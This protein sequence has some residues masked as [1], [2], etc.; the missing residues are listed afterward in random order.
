[1]REKTQSEQHIKLN[2]GLGYQY[3]QLNARERRVY[4]FVSSLSSDELF[5]AAF[6]AG[7]TDAEKLWASK[8]QIL[9]NQCYSA[10][11]KRQHPNLRSFDDIEENL[12]LIKESKYFQQV[13]NLNARRA[14]LILIARV[15]FIRNRTNGPVSTKFDKEN[16]SKRHLLADL[17]TASIDYQL[18]RQELQDLDQWFTEEWREI[19]KTDEL[20]LRTPSKEKEEEFLDELNLSLEKQHPDTPKADSLAEFLICLDRIFTNDKGLRKAFVKMA[21]SSLAQ[22]KHR[23]KGS[24]TQNNLSLKADIAKALEELANTYDLSKAQVVSVLVKAEKKNPV[25]LEEMK[26]WIN[27]VDQYTSVGE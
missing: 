23:Q 1:M 7:I 8:P 15:S 4:D 6:V 21:R 24:T 2:L 14:A 17:L 20:K 3:G 25:H 22:K 18:T 11:E 27:A 26:N 13:S 12:T 19:F 5:S 9:A 16:Y 10:L